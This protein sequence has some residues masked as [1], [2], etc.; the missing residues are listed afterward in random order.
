MKRRQNL[1]RLLAYRA[2][3]LVRRVWIGATRHIEERD[4]N[5][6][7]FRFGKISCES[8]ASTKPQL[9]IL[10]MVVVVNIQVPKSAVY[11]IDFDSSRNTYI[12]ID[13]IIT[14]N[15]SVALE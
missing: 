5:A 6:Q 9:D 1:Q 12:N 3:R 11:K 4:A 14:R 10:A 7:Y 8:T 15:T 13:R 2:V